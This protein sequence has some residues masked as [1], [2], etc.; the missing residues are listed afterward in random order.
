MYQT[1]LQEKLYHG[2]ASTIEHVDVTKGRG[3]KDF[4]K[5]FYIAV[6]RKQAIGMM[7]KKY[8]E[9]M[10]RNRNKR[11]F[12]ATEN[13]YEITL[14][15]EYAKL[16][17]IKI[18]PTADEEWLDF[19]L[20]CREDGGTPHEYDLVIGPTADDD[21]MICLRAYWDG[22]YGKVGSAEAKRVLLN[23]LE[24]ENLG[25]QYFISKQDIADRL[26]KNFRLADWRNYAGKEN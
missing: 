8:K 21:T 13:L 4:G 10:V 26:I 2:T 1:E 5:G 15:L 24:P 11:N 14:D 20:M 19:I 22:L 9:V 7:H 3:R 17:K 16:L 18:F 6:S 23:N 25:V 12:T